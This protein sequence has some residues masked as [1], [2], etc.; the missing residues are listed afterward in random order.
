M[1]AQLHWKAVRDS[2][3]TSD[4][5]LFIH[6]EK[7]DLFNKK[8]IKFYSRRA[9]MMS[10]C[11][12]QSK[13]FYRSRKAR[14]RDWCFFLCYSISWRG[15]K[16][17]S[18]GPAPFT[19]PHWLSVSFTISCWRSSRTHSNIFIVWHS[20]CRGLEMRILL[21]ACLAQ[22][23]TYEQRGVG[24]TLIQIVVVCDAV[25]RTPR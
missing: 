22:W 1:Y 7:S 23:V 4:V 11:G 14:F 24:Y 2:D 20:C 21:C 13:A 25:V 19:N 9:Y 17:A 8:F 12:T 10:W 3:G 18:Q 6:V 15:V 16:T 5:A